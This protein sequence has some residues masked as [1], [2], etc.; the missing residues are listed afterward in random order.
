MK[1]R[2]APGEFRVSEVDS[3]T[4]IRDQRVRAG[5]L[6]AGRMQRLRPRRVRVWVRRLAGS[7][8]LEES[9]PVAA[10]LRFAVHS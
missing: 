9:K 8:G 6:I 7:R 1:L 3:G 4:Q 5:D 2:V 10:A